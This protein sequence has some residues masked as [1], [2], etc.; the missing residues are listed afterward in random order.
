M[1]NESKGSNSYLLKHLG[2]KL[3]ENIYWVST[4]A[5]KNEEQYPVHSSNNR[6]GCW[7]DISAEV[8]FNKSGHPV[9]RLLLPRCL[10]AGS[11]FEH[12]RCGVHG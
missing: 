11:G 9:I 1:L 10:Q 6:S 4:T 2:I 7:P 8:L 3:N 5:D 12:A